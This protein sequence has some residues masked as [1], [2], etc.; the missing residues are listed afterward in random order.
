MDAALSRETSTSIADF[1]SKNSR[2]SQI[3]EPPTPFV[4]T[5]SSMK[6]GKTSVENFAGP[7]FTPISAYS[8]SFQQL[9]IGLDHGSAT[10]KV[11]YSLDPKP[12]PRTVSCIAGYPDDASGDTTE[13]PSEM[14]IPLD[15]EFWRRSGKRKHHLIVADPD[16]PRIGGIDQQSGRLGNHIC[17]GFL[18]GFEAQQ[19]FGMNHSVGLVLKMGCSFAM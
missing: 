4:T 6:T 16:D 13:V 12:E 1:F 19:R 2:A 15:P 8:Q 14:W 5:M 18:W 11:A 17:N 9:T 3:R 7:S 10:S